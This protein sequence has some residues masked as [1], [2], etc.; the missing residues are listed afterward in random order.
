VKPVESANVERI[1]SGRG[2][3]VLHRL[4]ERSGPTLLALHALAGSAR[5][6][7]A[8]ASA[9]PGPMWALD[10]PGHG[11]SPR[12]RGSSYTAELFAADADAALRTLG[13]AHVVGCG[14]GAYVALL[15]A[16][17]RPDRVPGALLLPGRG[18]AGGGAAPDLATPHAERNARVLA[19]LD[20]ADDPGH[21]ADPLTTTCERDPRPPEYARTFADAARRLLLAE[22]GDARPPWWEAA[23]AT[24]SAETVPAEP[25]EALARLASG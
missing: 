16:G 21:D 17:T 23:R 5:D 4:G 9:W 1:P 10:F 6:F 11:A 2:E 13:E 15:V 14:L 25:A 18:F 24:A 12:A 22:P 19:M 7:A 3:I 8:L 20:A